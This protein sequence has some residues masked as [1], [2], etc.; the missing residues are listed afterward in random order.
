M[1]SRLS[2]EQIVR[3]IYSD[4]DKTLAFETVTTLTPDFVPTSKLSFE[5]ILKAIYDEDTKTI[6]VS[7][8]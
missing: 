6:R 1:S 4:A 5:Q 7:E 3:E 8:G 2:K